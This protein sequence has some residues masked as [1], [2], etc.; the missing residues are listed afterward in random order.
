MLAVASVFSVVVVVMMCPSKGM[1]FK[2][3][4]FSNGGDKL[5]LAIKRD[6]SISVSI[7][8]VLSI[9]RLKQRNANFPPR[10][11]KVL[12]KILAS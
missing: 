2:M 6:Y 8:E 11:A 5:D 10:L 7:L 3:N 1:V 4:N 12:R 9:C